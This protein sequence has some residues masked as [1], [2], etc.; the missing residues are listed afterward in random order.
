M[1]LAIAIG[2]SLVRATPADPL[3][4]GLVTMAGAVALFMLPSLLLF[5]LGTRI[6]HGERMAAYGLAAVATI[7]AVGVMVVEWRWGLVVMAVLGVV[8]A[9][10][11]RVA[12][13]DAGGF[14]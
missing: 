2:K 9:P 8:L 11:C 3:E 14:H 6:M 5:Y 1:C 4:G 10:L 12:R 13:R 7:V